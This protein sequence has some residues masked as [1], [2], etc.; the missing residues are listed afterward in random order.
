ML[1]EW[2]DFVGPKT[3][4]AKGFGGTYL[5]NNDEEDVSRLY[6]M[7]HGVSLC[8]INKERAALYYECANSEAAQEKAQFWEDRIQKNALAILSVRMD[9]VGE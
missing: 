6:L 7:A 9:S 8:P 1:L 4:Q 5:I 2:E 3:L